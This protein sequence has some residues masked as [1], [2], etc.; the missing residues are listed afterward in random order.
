MYRVSEANLSSAMKY[1]YENYIEPLDKNHILSYYPK[2]QKNK[3]WLYDN[4]TTGLIYLNKHPSCKEAWVIVKFEYNT[5]KTYGL[6]TKSNNRQKITTPQELAN[7]FGCSLPTQNFYDDTTVTVTWNKEKIRNEHANRDF[8]ESAPN[9]YMYTNNL[10]VNLDKLVQR[11]YRI[12]TLLD[13]DPNIIKNSMF[14]IPYT[15]TNI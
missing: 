14:S 12:N 11:L 10:K 13:V 2:S 15:N 6:T 4:P 5:D 8:D 9:F 7:F 1:V 3:D